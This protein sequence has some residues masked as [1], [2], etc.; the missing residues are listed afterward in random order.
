MALTR[1]GPALGVIPNVK[2]D[3]REMEI[4]PGQLLFA[5]TDGAPDALNVAGARLGRESL[6]SRLQAD[7]SAE[8][9]LAQISQELTEYMTG[10]DQ[11]D[12]ITLLAV[13]RLP[14]GE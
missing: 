3:V 4:K 10:A 7:L 8:M 2:F 12:D 11:F 1:T 9:L 6:F 14:V 13:R 5:F